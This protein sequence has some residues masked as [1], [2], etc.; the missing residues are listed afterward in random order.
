MCPLD[1]WWWSPPDFKQIKSESQRSFLTTIN[2]SRPSY[3]KDYKFKCVFFFKAHSLRAVTNRVVC[4]LVQESCC[5]TELGMDVGHNPH[6]CLFFN[7]VICCR[8]VLWQSGN[9]KVLQYLRLTHHT[10]LQVQ[11]Y[12]VVHSDTLIWELLIYFLLPLKQFYGVILQNYIHT[13]SWV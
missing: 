9:V 7:S 13:C 1:Q 10:R 5:P 3:S 11:S 12:G 2:K 6:V 8:T 4:R